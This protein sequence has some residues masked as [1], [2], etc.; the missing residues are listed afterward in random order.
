VV[1]V[2]RLAHLSQND[3]QISYFYVAGQ[4]IRVHAACDACGNRSRANCD[5]SK[6][7]IHRLTLPVD[8]FGRYGSVVSKPYQVIEYHSASLVE[9]PLVGVIERAANRFLTP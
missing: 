3:P 2:S 9:D 5:R 7:S 1:R 6:T 8:G 4:V